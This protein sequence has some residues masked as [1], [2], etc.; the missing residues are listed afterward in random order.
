MDCKHFGTTPIAFNGLKPVWS[1]SREQIYFKII[2]CESSIRKKHSQKHSGV[3]EFVTNLVK[4]HPNFCHLLLFSWL[5]HPMLIWSRPVPDNNVPHSKHRAVFDLSM[6]WAVYFSQAYWSN[7]PEVL[8][9]E[10]YWSDQT[11]LNLSNDVTMWNLTSGRYFSTSEL[12]FFNVFGGHIHISYFGATGAPV[13]D[14]WWCLLWVSKPG[15]ILHYS[16]LQRRM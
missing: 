9:G 1:N 10:M 5:Q 2:W 16:L 11:R 3:V 4:F 8:I 7:W 15:W 6:S 13:L 12:E 14:F